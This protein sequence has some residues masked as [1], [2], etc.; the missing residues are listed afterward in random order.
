M[1]IELHRISNYEKVR[2]KDIWIKVKHNLAHSV[3]TN[4]KFQNP[5]DSVLIVVTDYRDLLIQALLF[6]FLFIVTA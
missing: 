5:W 4:W 3:P 2:N 6:K 1:K